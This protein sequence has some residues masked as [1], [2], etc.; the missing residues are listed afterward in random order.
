LV[1]DSLAKKK[2]RNFSK[3]YRKIYEH[4]YSNFAITINCKMAVTYKKVKKK[5]RNFSIKYRKIYEHP[6]SVSSTI[7][8][9]I[10]G[11]LYTTLF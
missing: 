10:R 11:E 6:Y 4:H 1:V 2:V 3:K 8:S 9:Q 5:V 7:F